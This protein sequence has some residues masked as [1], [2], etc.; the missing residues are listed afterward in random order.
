VGA[1]WNPANPEVAATW[2]EAGVVLMWTISRSQPLAV[3]TGHKGR[4]TA[5]AWEPSGARFVTASIDGTARRWDPEIRSD[6]AP[7]ATSLSTASFHPKDPGRLVVAGSDGA[8]T[9]LGSDQRSHSDVFA[10]LDP[11]PR[12]WA[13]FS[14]DGKWLAATRVFDRRVRIVA[15]PQPGEGWP[16]PVLDEHGLPAGEPFASADNYDVVAWSACGRYLAVKHLRRLVVWDLG[17]A[18]GGAPRRVAERAEEAE[19]TAVAWHPSRP[20]LAAAWWGEPVRVLDAPREPGSGWEPVFE[21]EHPTGVWSVDWSHDG[22]QVLTGGND[23][24]VRVFDVPAG[25]GDAIASVDPSLCVKMADQVQA[26]AGS[27]VDR[28][29]AAGDV[30]GKVAVFDPRLGPK[31][32]DDSLIAAAE[33]APGPVRQVRFSPDGEWLVGAA[34]SALVWR[35]LPGTPRKGS[36]VLA[37][38]LTAADACVVG[39]GFGPDGKR[40]VTAADSGVSSVEPLDRASLLEATG[41]RLR[42]RKMTDAEWERYMGP[43]P[44]LPTWPRPAE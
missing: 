18:P 7:I 36:F 25:G 37:S 6:R 19:L 1:A 43:L 28:L 41:R 34:L 15:V 14:P 22:A 16:T 39:V 35:R 38:R 40:V 21:L 30:Q 23:G 4:I 42:R 12:A 20:R 17:D 11:R 13:A 31:S 10:E 2:N 27:P 3:L 29:F 8:V 5:A 32:L 24:S 44:A 33:P 9:V 26:V